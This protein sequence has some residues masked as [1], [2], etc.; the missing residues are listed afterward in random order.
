[1]LFVALHEIDVKFLFFQLSISS[2]TEAQDE[3]QITSA[4]WEEYASKQDKKKTEHR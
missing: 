3:E 4:S 1:M 2:W